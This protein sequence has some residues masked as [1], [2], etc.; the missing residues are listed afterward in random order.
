MT[1]WS[2]FFLFKSDWLYNYNYYFLKENNNSKKKKKWTIKF[3][4]GEILTKKN[5]WNR[6][7]FYKI[8]IITTNWKQAVFVKGK[9]ELLTLI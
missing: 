9:K 1:R 8:I 5:E 7:I 3:I 4:R 6:K 2:F